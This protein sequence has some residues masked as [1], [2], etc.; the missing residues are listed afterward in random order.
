M[1]SLMTMS[2]IAA[3]FAAR[4]YK[5]TSQREAIVR[6]LLE[7]ETEHLTVEDIYLKM[8]PDHPNLG[9]ATIY[10][11]LD[12]LSELHIV[13]KMNFGDGPA[14]YDLR[15]G[16]QGHMH[17]HLICEDCGEL[18]EI[19]EDWL[20]ELEARL[21]R[22]YGF[23]VTDHRLDFKGRFKTCERHD[24]RSARTGRQVG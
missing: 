7:N 15:G 23:L 2:D 6:V 3:Q 13:E 12:L 20:A 1:R 24:C 21:E 10:R 5:L 4:Q 8:K 16:G 14:R 19:K 11:T 17:H 18:T 9:M 22:E